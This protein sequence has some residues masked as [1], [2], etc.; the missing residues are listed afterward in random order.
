M[1]VKFKER[2]QWYKIFYVAK[3]IATA[4]YSKNMTKNNTDNFKQIRR[5]ELG[6]K[7]LFATYLVQVYLSIQSSGKPIEHFLVDDQF[8]SLH[9]ITLNIY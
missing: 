3:A 9:L 8:L 1:S 4:V 7:H 2:T 5:L 6:K